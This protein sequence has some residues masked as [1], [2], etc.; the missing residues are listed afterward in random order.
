MTFLKHLCENGV[1]DGWRSVLIAVLVQLDPYIEAT[2]SPEGRSGP[3]L[4]PCTQCRGY[5]QL[6]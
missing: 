1:E 6:G 4:C 3:L 5:T 2:G